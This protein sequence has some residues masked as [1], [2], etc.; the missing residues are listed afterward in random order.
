MNLTSKT[1]ATL[2]AK[3]SEFDAALKLYPFHPMRA[4]L[5]VTNDDYWQATWLFNNWLGP[6]WNKKFHK[7]QPIKGT[8]FVR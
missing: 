7:P 8:P 3:R 6:D 5:S 1:V 2:L 4:A